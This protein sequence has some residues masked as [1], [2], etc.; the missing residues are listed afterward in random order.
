MNINFRNNYV[1]LDLTGVYHDGTPAITGT[2][3]GLPYATFTRWIEGADT[4]ENETCVDDNNLPDAKQAL[5]DAGI[6]VDTGKTAI[7]GYCTYSI[8]KLLHGVKL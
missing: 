4:D 3:N 7:M 6:V 8:V 1:K 2:V 5:I